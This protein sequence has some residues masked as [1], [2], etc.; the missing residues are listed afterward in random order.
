[1]TTRKKY[2]RDTDLHPDILEHL[3][4]ESLAMLLMTS[5]RELK[6]SQDRDGRVPFDQMDSLVC[7]WSTD[8]YPAEWGVVGI[9]ETFDQTLSIT[10]AE[11]FGR[12][13]WWEFVRIKREERR[14]ETLQATLRLIDELC[15]NEAAEEAKKMEERR[16]NNG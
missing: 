14:E 16:R 4:E 1:M 5:M 2:I 8:R 10:D 12:D 11:D 7:I 3:S 9:V 15:R 6:G 13:E